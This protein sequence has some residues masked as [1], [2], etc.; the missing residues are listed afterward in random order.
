M[1][2][3]RVRFGEW[4]HC[5]TLTWP[6]RQNSSCVLQSLGGG[7]LRGAGVDVIK[8]TGGAAW[9]TV[10]VNS[11]AVVCLAV[12]GCA[13]VGSIVVVQNEVVAASG[14]V[15]VG[16][17]I[18][19]KDVVMF[20]A[21]VD[22]ATEVVAATDVDEEADEVGA[23]EVVVDDDVVG[24]GVVEDEE[25]V[26]TGLLVVEVVM[27]A[28]AHNARPFPH[29]TTFDSTLM[30]SPSDPA[31]TSPVIEIPNTLPGFVTLPSI[32]PAL[33]KRIV[34][35]FGKRSVALVGHW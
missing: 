14:V 19:E 7:G 3:S 32:I 20:D 18:F 22:A 13:V 10:V 6:P 33:R 30:I 21:D 12:V 16:V 11:T 34:M 5:P 9:A 35:R 28:S 23:G 17:V 26:G 4:C 24:A 15:G 8:T 27:G 1:A 29:L 25:V 31:P 2:S